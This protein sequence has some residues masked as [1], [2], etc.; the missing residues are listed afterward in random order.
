MSATSNAKVEHIIKH[1]EKVFKKKM[2]ILQQLN[3]NRLMG[4]EKEFKM[5]V[6]KKFSGLHENSER[7]INETSNKINEWKEFFFFT[8]NKHIFYFV[9]ILS[10][11]LM[12]TS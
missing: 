2:I 9:Y 11:C 4:S 12:L 1:Y 7:Q 3:S 8:L 6:I 10:P 5:A